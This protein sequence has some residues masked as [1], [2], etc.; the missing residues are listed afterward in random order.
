[1]GFEEASTPQER[2]LFVSCTFTILVVIMNFLIAY[3]GDS[4][5]KARED[6]V[7]ARNQMRAELL[8]EIEMGML[9]KDE[10]SRSYIFTCRGIEMRTPEDEGR[11]YSFAA[12]Q[13]R[14]E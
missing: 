13:E 10:P 12:M 9:E 7:A 2:F 14:V 4:F 8:Y 6:L 5:N 1:M 3:M 11:H